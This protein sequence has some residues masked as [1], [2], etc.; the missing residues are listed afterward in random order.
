MHAFLGADCKHLASCKLREHV[1]HYLPNSLSESKLYQFG[2]IDMDCISDLTIDIL[3]S[4]HP[5]RSEM[6]LDE[7]AMRRC[8]ISIGCMKQRLGQS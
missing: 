4:G 5:K 2:K 1:L 3:Y 8:P 7:S 6:V